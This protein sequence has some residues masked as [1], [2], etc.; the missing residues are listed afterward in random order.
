MDSRAKPGTNFQAS[1]NAG[2]T[3]YNMFVPNNPMRNITNNQAS[4]I[5]YSR[6]W[7]GN[8]PLN[9]TLSANQNQNSYNHF[10]ADHL[11]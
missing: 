3:K 6:T 1:V 9:L 8:T 5:S 2:S 7:S 10:N 4:S 11:A